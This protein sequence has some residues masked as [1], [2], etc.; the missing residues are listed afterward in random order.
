MKKLLL[1]KNSV[2]FFLVAFFMFSLNLSA[3]EKDVTK[4]TNNEKQ[5]ELIETLVW[6]KSKTGK[7][8]YVNTTYGY[9]IYSELNYNIESPSNISL[10]I[11]K[12]ETDEIINTYKFNLKDIYEMYVRYVYQFNNIHLITY[13]NQRLISLDK[14]GESYTT[15]EAS[16]YYDNSVSKER[17][18]KALNYLLKLSGGGKRVIKEKF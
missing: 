14:N 17:M 10:N 11:K 7:D 18:T 1:S 9:K 15:Y 4:L 3:Q 5:K 2:C 16:I 8:F 6:L 12:Y 13:E